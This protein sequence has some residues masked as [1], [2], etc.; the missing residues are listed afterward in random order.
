MS[1]FGYARVSQSLDAQVKELKAAG[2]KRLYQEKG[3]GAAADRAR[4]VA[5][6]VRL[7]RRPK[8]SPHQQQE[9]RARRNS[10][11]AVSEIA[12]SYNV[13]HSTISRLRS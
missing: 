10:G 3:S 8:L 7:G 2:A 9:A 4:A 1:V 6:C 12:R 5:R 13:H 11:E